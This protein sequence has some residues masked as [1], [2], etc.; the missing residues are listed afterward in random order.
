MEKV[1]GLMYL[2]ANRTPSCHGA[3]IISSWA[4]ISLGHFLTILSPLASIC[5]LKW[6]IDC[7]LIGINCANGAVILYNMSGSSSWE[8]ISIGL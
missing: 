2:F 8:V 5:D 3:P 4:W 6:E 7:K 1:N